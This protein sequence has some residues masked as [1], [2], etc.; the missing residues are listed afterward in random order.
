MLQHN[1]IVFLIDILKF[2]FLKKILSIL[3]HTYEIGEKVLKKLTVVYIQNDLTFEYTVQTLSL[4]KYKQSHQKYFFSSTRVLP[5]HQTA[6]IYIIFFR[7]F[8]IYI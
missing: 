6:T 1:K 8:Y 7:N 2:F 5:T 3:T 4:F